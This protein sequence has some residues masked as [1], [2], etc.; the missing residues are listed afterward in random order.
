MVEDAGDGTVDRASEEDVFALVGNE[1]RAGIIRALGDARDAGDPRVVVPF[2]DLRAALDSDARSSR[3][4]YHLQKLVGTFVEQ[5]A[6][7]YRLR[8]EGSTLYRTLEGGTF[9]Y[10]ASLDAVD[11]DLDCYHCGTS[12]DATY[13][14]GEFRID[15]QDCGALYETT[16]RI[17]SLAVDNGEDVLAR[18]DQYNRHKRLAFTRGICPTCA[19]SVSAEFVGPET[20]PFEAVTRKVYIQYRCVHCG[21]Q[22]LL[23]VGEALLWDPGLVAFCDEHGRDIQSIPV[24]NLRFAATDQT[25]TVEAR[26]PWRVTLRV[27]A[28][29]EVLE[30]VV[31]NEVTVVGRSVRPLN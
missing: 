7:G 14:S 13:N 4:N 5:T 26:E 18:I 17:P 8:P 20:I 21:N 2:S 27:P 12:V 16:T 11:V 24:W 19:Q 3:F 31:N 1:I 9:E 15:C 23:S 22:E 28:D 6:D 29:E 30:L 10:R 25:V